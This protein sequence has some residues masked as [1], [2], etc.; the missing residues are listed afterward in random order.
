MG[1]SCFCLPLCSTCAQPADSPNK[2]VGAQTYSG[3]G[4]IHINCI[5][6][7]AYAFRRPL[8][9]ISPRIDWYP[10]QIDWQFTSAR[11]DWYLTQI[12]QQFTYCG[13]SVSCARRAPP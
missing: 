9:S 2:A 10:T 13:L 11:I 5:I 4:T 6:G 8:K 1:N 12:D 3:C 7:F